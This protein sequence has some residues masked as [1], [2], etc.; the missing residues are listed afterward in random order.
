GPDALRGN[1]RG[2][3]QAHHDADLATSPPGHDHPVAGAHCHLAPRRREVVE[4]GRDRHVER[5]PDIP[6]RFAAG[7]GIAPIRGHGI[8]RIRRH[9]EITLSLDS[10]GAQPKRYRSPCTGS[11]DNFVEKTP[12]TPQSTRH[13]PASRALTKNWAIEKSFQFRHLHEGVRNARGRVRN[14]RANPR[15]VYKSSD[16]PPL[17]GFGTPWKAAP[18]L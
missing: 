15:R 11:V 18:G 14:A 9:R 4:P 12:R 5:D 3:R 17:R 13:R 1:A 16:S 7:A 6:G 8:A 2:I 10:N